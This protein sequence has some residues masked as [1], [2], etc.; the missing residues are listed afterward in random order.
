MVTSF[1]LRLMQ[2]YRSHWD[3]PSNRYFLANVGGND[4]NNAV[5]EI[6]LGTQNANFGWPNCEGAC[7]NPDF[8]GCSCTKYKVGKHCLPSFLRII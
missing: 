5:E 8:S 1:P 3:I 6:Y 2:A 4:Q 7:N